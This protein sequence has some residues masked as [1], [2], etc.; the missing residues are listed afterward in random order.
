MITD[1]RLIPIGLSVLVALAFFVGLS[2]F[3]NRHG[4]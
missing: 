2:Y 4:K 3:A 1:E